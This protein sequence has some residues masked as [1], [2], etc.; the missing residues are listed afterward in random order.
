M[1]QNRDHLGSLG[2]DTRAVHAGERVAG[3]PVIPTTTPIYQ[4][5]SFSYRSTDE[6]DKVFDDNSSGYVYT[7]YGNPTTRALEAA[8]ATLEGTADAV[9]FPSG[10]A[11]IAAALTATVAN[12]EALLASQDVYGA[13]FAFIQNELSRFGVE[14]QFINVLDLA[15][16]QRTVQ[17]R[18]PAAI[19]VETISNPLLRVADIRAIA[20]ISGEAGAKL[21]VDNTFA[22]PVLVNPAALGAD[23]VIHSTTKYLGGHG[24][25]TG[26]VIATNAETARRLREQAKLNGAVAGPFDAWL[27]LRGIKTLPLRM[28]HQCDSAATIAAWLARHGAIDRVYY[29]GKDSSLPAGQFNDGRAGAMVSFEIRDAER[30]QVFAFLDA[31][32]LCVPATTLGDVYSLVL[33]PAMS[34]HRALTSEQ[35]ASIGIS[36]GLVRLS[37]GIENAEDIMNDLDQALEACQRIPV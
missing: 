35:R 33:Y 8:V 16:L 28:R 6:L 10:M 17:A 21:I 20:R 32:Q 14:G 5:S 24:D 15:G 23:M 9:A 1:G 13:T 3:G 36:D 27:T 29:P 11:A 30:D 7:R 22:T 25:V 2:T 26:G 19:I 12:G 18:K 4:T 34:S 31:L 37:V